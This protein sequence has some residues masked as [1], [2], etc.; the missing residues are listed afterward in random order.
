MYHAKGEIVLNQYDS[1]T[2]LC[3]LSDIVGHRTIE[4]CQSSVQLRIAVKHLPRR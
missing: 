2:L 4:R 3:C 1:L